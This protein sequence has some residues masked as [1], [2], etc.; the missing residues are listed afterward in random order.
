MNQYLEAIRISFF[1]FPL[2]A[3]LSIVPYAY[4]QYKKIGYVQFNRSLVFYIFAFY[5][6]T[7]FFI[8]ILPLPEVSADFCNNRRGRLIP[9]FFPFRFLKMLTRELRGNISLFSIVKSPTLMVTAFN[10]LLLMPLGFFL[11]YLFQ[12]KNIGVATMIGFLVSLF[13]EI[14]QLTALY[15]LYPCRYRQFEVDDLITNTFGCFIGF[16]IARYSNLLPNISSK[17]LL[18]RTEVTLTQRFLAIFVDSLLVIFFTSY[19]IEGLSQ[20]IWLQSLMK[21]GT[22]VFYFIFVSK[23]TNGQ[24]FGKKLLGIRIVRMDGTR[25]TYKDLIARYSVFLILPFFVGEVSKF[26]LDTR[27][28]DKVYLFLYL[29]FLAIWFFGTVMVT[30]IR[31]DHRGWL[32]RFAHTTQVLAKQDD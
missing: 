13:Y 3:L 11:R 20:N 10:V 28:D 24:T 21:V 22:I 4:F 30:F 23:I 9:S 8:T 18:N 17:P 32:D 12:I 2:V 26:L 19:V 5:A 14:T 25:L 27:F 31:K 1:Y 29:L 16:L 15:G 7:A 6:M